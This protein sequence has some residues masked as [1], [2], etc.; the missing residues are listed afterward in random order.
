MVSDILFIPVVQIVE[1]FDDYDKI[2]RP[3]MT[4]EQAV[5]LNKEILKMFKPYIPKGKEIGISPVFRFYDVADYFERDLSEDV[6]V[7]I[8]GMI[9]QMNEM[10]KYLPITSRFIH[11]STG[12]F[13]LPDEIKPQYQMPTFNDHTLNILHYMFPVHIQAEKESTLVKFFDNY[14]EDESDHCEKILDG[15][16]ADL[17]HETLGLEKGSLL[18]VD[19]MFDDAELIAE[20]FTEIEMLIEETVAEGRL[21]LLTE[22]Q[23]FHLN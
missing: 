18:L 23:G 19:P 2:C 10:D 8:D 1:T 17:L 13:F 14:F 21:G 11:S 22:K 6:Y 15:K 16:F 20:V 4:H 5:R 7:V 12:E 9:E 3:K